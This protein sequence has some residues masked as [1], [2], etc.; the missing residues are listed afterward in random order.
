MSINRKNQNMRFPI[1]LLDSIDPKWTL[2]GI[3]VMRRRK[4]YRQRPILSL[5]TD[6]GTKEGYIGAMKGV[7]YRICPLVTLVDISHHITKHSIIQGAF[8]VAQHHLI[9]RM[10][11]FI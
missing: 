6:F 1:N 10:E 9:F 4:M 3:D 8:I 7:I 2:N 5:T 11:P